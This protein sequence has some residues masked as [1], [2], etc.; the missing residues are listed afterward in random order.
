MLSE[1]FT[2]LTT[3]C[4]RY[5]RH[6]D[7]LSEAIAMRE[8]YRRNLNAWQPHLEH[9]R[10]FILDAASRC[11][12]RSKV[13]VLGAGLLLDVP[14]A[15]LSKMFREVVLLDIVLLP[16]ISREVKKYCNATVIQNDVTNMAEKLYNNIQK[17]VRGLPEAA[18]E[19]S[20]LFDNAG[21]VVSLNILSQLWVMPR[22][23]ALGKLPRIDEEKLDDWCRQIVESHYAFLLSFSC[24]VCLIADHEF[25]KRDREGA[26]VGRGTTV[27]GFPLPEPHAS[28]TWNIV[29]LC[30]DGQYASK[31]LTVGA[32]H[33]R[34]H[35][36]EASH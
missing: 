7:Y 3:S 4:P 30:G 10:R 27:A 25:I 5:V 36:E 16:D 15:E 21:L 2:Y 34:N 17:G 33:L 12:E 6:M 35:P 19:I 23:Y 28:W 26:I 1:F 29:P 22:V 8:R 18:P 14:L 31:E 13:V 24:P 20:P 11:R 32:W 9:S